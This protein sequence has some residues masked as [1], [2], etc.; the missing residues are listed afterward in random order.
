MKKNQQMCLMVFIWIRNY[1]ITCYRSEISCWSSVSIYNN[2]KVRERFQV[3]LILL[4]TVVFWFIF[5][6]WI[7]FTD[8]SFN[9]QQLF[10]N[11]KFFHIFC[12]S[13]I[14]RWSFVCVTWSEPECFSVCRTRWRKPAC[15]IVG[16]FQEQ[17]HQ[18]VN[19]LLDLWIS[20]PVH[21]AVTCPSVVSTA[22]V[23]W[24]ERWRRS[25]S[26]DSDWSSI[27]GERLMTETL[28]F[29]FVFFLL[30]RRRIGFY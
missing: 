19:W 10:D 27:A 5:N 26:T 8:W 12:Y 25:R 18:Q 1:D 24:C 3:L 15:C 21:A 20:F 28:R 17:F 13:S 29:I 11:Q 2:Q 6:L 23:T 14:V 16:S 30:K 22:T 7:S 4:I 9:H